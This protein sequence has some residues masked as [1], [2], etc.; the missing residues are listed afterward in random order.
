MTASFS[1][2]LPHRRFAAFGMR[3][4]F[5]LTVAG[6]GG[7]G[8][9]SEL[10]LPAQAASN[11]AVLLTNANA[12]GEAGTVSLSGPLDPSHPFFKPLGNGRSCATC[13]R[14]DDG[15]TITPAGVQ[16][17]FEQTGGLDSLFKPHDAANSPLA[18]VSSVEARRAAYSMLLAKGV[19]RMGLPIPANAE[20]ELAGVDDPYAYA[21]ANELSLFRRPPPAAN[22]SFLTAVMW[23]GGETYADPNS[24]M[25]FFGTNDCY[26]PPET[27][28]GNQALH[29]VNRHA[30]FAAGLTASEQAAIVQFEKGLFTAQLSDK[31]AGSLNGAGAG[32]GPAALA[33]AAFYFGINDFDAGDYRTRAAF[34][35]KASTLYDAWNASAPPADPNT[36]PAEAAAQTAARQAIARGQ[37]LFNNAPIFLNSVPGLKNA[38]VRGT[39]TTCHDAPN[40]GTHSTPLLFNLGLS[41][42]GRRTPDLPLYTLRN[43]A[44][45]ALT[46]TTDPGAAMA[47]GR[48]GD[49]GRFKVPVLRGLAARAPYFHNGSAKDLTEVVNFYNERFKIGFTPQEIADLVA[50]LNAL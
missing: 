45:G 10:S 24:G 37:T 12:S 36:A 28:L 2:S 34:T 17:R 21:S 42:A 50:Y 44:T 35:P 13:H 40:V 11:T 27:N 43:K 41:D 26:A 19:I 18:D 48:W 32:G 25:C 9:G 8:S 1:I 16:A 31:A 23:D 30:Q 49:I 15:W 47:T 14:Q 33:S 38:S 46:Q 7:G 3:L 6:C 22:A 20:F 29:A 4:V 39:C 5:A